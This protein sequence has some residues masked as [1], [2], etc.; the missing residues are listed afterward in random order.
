MRYI[1]LQGRR[2]RQWDMSNALWTHLLPDWLAAAAGGGEGGGGGVHLRQ[3]KESTALPFLP[4]HYLCYRCTL[5]KVD[6]LSWMMDQ[7][8]HNLHCIRLEIQQNESFLATHS[9]AL[10][11]PPLLYQGHASPALAESEWGKAPLDWTWVMLW[12]ARSLHSI[13][14]RLSELLLLLLLSELLL[15]LLLSSLS[16]SELLDYSSCQKTLCT[17][18]PRL[19]PLAAPGI[20]GT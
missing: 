15:L 13:S 17:A 7:K 14:I 4:T 18:R 6:I 10:S 8:L 20:A 1:D 2:Q 5:W 16:L 3:Q 12:G 9:I 11:S 19:L